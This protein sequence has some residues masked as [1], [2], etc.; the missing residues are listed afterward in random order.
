MGTGDIKLV[1]YCKEP[2]AALWKIR[3][4]VKQG[5]SIGLYGDQGAS[6]RPGL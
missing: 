4:S 2:N 5:A 1:L 6:V 3:L